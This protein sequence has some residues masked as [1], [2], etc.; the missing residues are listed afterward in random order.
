[1]SQITTINGYVIFNYRTKLYA[2]SR[3]R[4][5]PCTYTKH[6]DYAYIY[7]DVTHAEIDITQIEHENDISSND[8]NYHET[9]EIKI[10]YEI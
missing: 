7:R 1:M 3:Q 6:V 9:K 8:N 5:R 2:M 10:T 4:N